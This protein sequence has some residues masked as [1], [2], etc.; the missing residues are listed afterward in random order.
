MM[1]KGAERK[2]AILELITENPT[3]TQIQ[4]MEKLNLSRKQIQTN[5]KKL[6]EEG[7]LVRDGSN[8][9]GHWVLKRID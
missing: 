2:Q 6:Q 3:I 1:K 9:K 4:L 5:I 7:I 8:R